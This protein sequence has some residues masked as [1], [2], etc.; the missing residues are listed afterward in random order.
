VDRIP[1]QTSDSL[2]VFIDLPG[3]VTAW[4]IAYDGGDIWVACEAPGTPIL[5]Y[6]SSSTIIDQIPSSLV[7]SAT[8]LTMDDSGYLW[9][10]DNVNQLIYKIDP[11]GTG[12]SGDDV[13]GTGM[14]E[15]HLSA[16]PF[17]GSLRV[18]VSGFP[19]PVG[20]TV[21]DV[22]GRVITSS[23]TTGEFLWD[24]GGT[25][26]SGMYSIIATDGRESVSAR[27]VLLR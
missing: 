27:A 17:S 22:S 11:L 1:Y 12:V 19:G 20:I 6:N 16:N 13:Q 3:A 2:L 24:T 23:V 8:G 7:P 21:L 26:P 9:A 14:P 4:D 5:K 25:L 18:T 15:V 10:S